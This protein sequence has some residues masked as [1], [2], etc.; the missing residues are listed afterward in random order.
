VPETAATT[1]S[2]DYRVHRDLARAISAVE[3]RGADFV[4]TAARF[5]ATHPVVR[6]RPAYA[7]GVTGPPGAGKSTLVD[8][9]I[10]K[11][12][13][14]GETVAVV[15]VDPSSPFTRGA[16][17]GDRVRMQQ[18]HGDA[19]VFIRSMASREAG[20]GLAPTTSQAIKLAELAGFDVAIVETVGV[21]QVELE[22]V[23]VADVVVVVTVPGLGDGVQ[24][25]KA[26]LTEIADMFVVNMA[27]RPGA[28][29]T[30]L[31]LTHMVH[32]S[33]RNVPVV[34]TVALDGT[35]IDDVMDALATLRAAGT[36]NAVRSVRF[37]VIRTVRD[38]AVT[39]AVHALASPAAQ[40][41]FTQLASQ[42]ISRADAAR[43]L[44]AIV[45]EKGG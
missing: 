41:I 15:A 34:K 45:R 16:V 29:L 37:E 9:L 25:I 39:E 5:S 18:H 17:L 35:G 8:R 2:I 7:I 38:L 20:G 28:N 32:E 21:G 30:A 10:A 26:G 6:T 24:T 42:T 14:A 23:S 4:E 43:S 44:V 33:G 3:N 31:E 40:E 12:R 19:G 11:F 36:A 1:A 22:V 13:A 27:D